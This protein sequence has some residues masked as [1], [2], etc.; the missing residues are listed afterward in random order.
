[1][2]EVKTKVLNVLIQVQVVDT[3]LTVGEYLITE[4][5]ADA[6]LDFCDI[7]IDTTVGDPDSGTQITQDAWVE[8]IWWEY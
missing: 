3:Q 2:K 7:T 4:F 6:S 1:M 8:N 5:G